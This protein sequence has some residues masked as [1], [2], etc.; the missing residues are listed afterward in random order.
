[1]WLLPSTQYWVS[2]TRR[3]VIDGGISLPSAAR[4]YAAALRK[5]RASIERFGN[6][7]IEPDAEVPT[8]RRKTG[9]LWIVP[10]YLHMMN[11]RLGITV[12]EEAYLGRVIADALTVEARA[13]GGQPAK[14]PHAAQELLASPL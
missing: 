5:A 12:L 7:A 10:S 11:N 9:P 1:M 4:R 2:D 6:H 14:P 13:F 8:S 3:Q